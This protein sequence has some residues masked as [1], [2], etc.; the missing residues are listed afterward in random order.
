MTTAPLTGKELLQK[1]AD[2]LQDKPVEQ[3]YLFG[4]YARG[5][6]DAVSDSEELWGGKRGRREETRW[7]QISGIH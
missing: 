3:V 2:A 7:R 4:S 1:L 5:E 6:A